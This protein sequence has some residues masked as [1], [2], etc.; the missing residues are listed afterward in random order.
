MEQER[1]QLLQ[2]FNKFNQTEVTRYTYHKQLVL[3]LHYTRFQYFT[4][5]SHTIVDIKMEIEHQNMSI[6]QP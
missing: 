1:H 4:N 6:S 3:I 5:L 2:A